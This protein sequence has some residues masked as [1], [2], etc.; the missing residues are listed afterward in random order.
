[1]TAT[2]T[3]LDCVDERHRGAAAVAALREW[4]QRPPVHPLLVRDFLEPSF[5]HKLAAAIGRLPNWRFHAQVLPSPDSAPV[6]V[7]AEEYW[8]F[9]AE[10]QLAYHDIAHQM[11]DVVTVPDMVSPEDLLVLRVF[12]Q[13]AVAGSTLSDWLETFLPYR[14]NGEVSVEFARYRDGQLLG[15]HADAVDNRRMAVNLYLDPSYVPERGAHLGYR[16]ETGASSFSVPWFN[17]ATLMPTR[18]DCRHWVTPYHGASP[19]RYVIALGF[20]EEANDE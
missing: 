10:Q 4:F 20:H 11:I 13:F 2:S 1:M 15:A 8:A 14:F 3:L 19:G 16:D 12:F 5:A 9:P 6:D 7:E 17:S 18:K